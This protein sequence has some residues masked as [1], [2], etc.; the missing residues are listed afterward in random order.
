MPSGVGPRVN[1]AIGGLLTLEHRVD[2]YFRDAF[3]GVF[4][5]PLAS[6]VQWGLRRTRTRRETMLCQEVPL[7]HED[8]V[9][10]AI[11]NA[12]IRFTEREYAGRIA[13]RAGNTKTY[14]V[15][16]AEFIVRDGLAERLRKGIFATPRR[17]P[18]WIRFGGP[19]PLSPPDVA[20]AGI[21]SIG[22][23]LMDVPGPK[24]F[25]G[26][27]ATQDFT[28]IS[29][30][31]F[32]TPNMVENLKLQKQIGAGTPAFYFLNPF[33]SH[34]LDFMMQGLYARM[35]SSPLETQ[36]W[37]CVPYLLGPGQAMKYSVRPRSSA[38]TKVP[39]NPPDDWLRQAM[40]QTLERHEVVLD[41]GIQLQTD[42]QRMP[43]EDASIEWPEN[44]SPFVA[45]ATIRIPP[46][47]F[48]SDAQLAFARQLSFNPW[49]AIAEHQ[50]LG[51]LN[52]GRRL[53]YSELARVRQAMNHE[54]HVE[55]TESNPQ[56]N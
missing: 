35:N 27:Q 19:G 13:E 53:I 40:R 32:T 5:R 12:M 46:Q 9:A 56:F 54:A 14:G 23:K 37:S 16:R 55:P 15:V 28:G 33:D 26:E 17:Y 22:I 29:C 11:T 42:A 47:H 31:T 50:P 30:P 2:P 1:D 48:D 10:Q 8:S 6:L 4:Q 34:Y 44:L 45:A 49:H 51:N 38:R 24:L 7:P 20:D 52:R 25:P 39:W 41:F 3:D 36:Y 21:L 18:A 43:I